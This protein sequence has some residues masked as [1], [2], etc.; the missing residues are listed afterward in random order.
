MGLPCLSEYIRIQACRS[1]RELDSCCNVQKVQIENAMREHCEMN[2]ADA[3]SHSLVVEDVSQREA[4]SGRAEKLAVVV[5]VVAAAIKF[6]V[7]ILLS[8][9]H[10]QLE[11][12]I[13]RNSLSLCRD[14]SVSL[15][16]LVASGC[17]AP[18]STTRLE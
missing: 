9:D 8:C 15:L 3:G 16:R 17:H 12:R 11:R 1:C 18:G 7:P 10:C 13:S 14:C 6:I 4:A 2:L 5:V